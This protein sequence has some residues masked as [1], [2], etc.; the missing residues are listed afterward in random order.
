MYLL[1]NMFFVYSPFVKGEQQQSCVP[2]L[3][4]SCVT[5]EQI[6]KQELDWLLWSES[7]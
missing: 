1:L 6:P 3:L 7:V 5:W 2:C 4:P